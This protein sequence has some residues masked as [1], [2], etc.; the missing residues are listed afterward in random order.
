VCGHTHIP[1][2]RVL[3]SGR[4]VINAGSVGKP[5]DNDPRACYIILEVEG[6]EL[7]VRFIRV[8]YDIEQAAG[9]IESSEMPDE[10]AG[11]LW[12]GAG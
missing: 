8:P 7:N 12:A 11:M 6:S 10:Y 5:K 9:A 1:Y 2:H 4:H 3:S